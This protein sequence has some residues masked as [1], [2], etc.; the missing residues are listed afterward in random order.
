MR[1][2]KI[3]VVTLMLVFSSELI[4]LWS[5]Y[6]WKDPGMMEAPKEW[7]CDYNGD[8]Q[9]NEGDEVIIREF[10]GACYELDNAGRAT[11]PVSYEESMIADLYPYPEHCTTE[12]DLRVFEQ[13]SSAINGEDR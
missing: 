11:R 10:I 12:E 1:I 6:T 5:I 13:I 2:S 9:C 8:Q 4:L 3:A 7:A